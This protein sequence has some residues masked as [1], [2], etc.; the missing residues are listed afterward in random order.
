VLGTGVAVGFGVAGGFEPV[1]WAM[2]E[3][4][5]AV[6]AARVVEVVAATV[7]GEPTVEVG[8][9]EPLDAHAEARSVHAAAAIASVV[10]CF[11][12][13]LCDASADTHLT[14]SGPASGRSQVSARVW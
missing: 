13:T 5:T 4:V 7:D 11:M 6:V 2:V 9:A 10:C 14:A 12:D 8:P 1:D 3:L